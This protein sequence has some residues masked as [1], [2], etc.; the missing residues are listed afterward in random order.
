MKITCVYVHTL[1]PIFVTAASVHTLEWFIRQ[2]DTL[3][4]WNLV[5]LGVTRLT[6]LKHFL[7]PFWTSIFLHSSTD[8]KSE[9]ARNPTKQR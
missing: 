6:V 1:L 8:Y 3:N 2:K 4:F 9:E 7:S 5:G